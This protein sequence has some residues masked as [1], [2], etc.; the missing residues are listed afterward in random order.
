[1]E[2]VT[3]LLDIPPGN[4]NAVPV[5]Y[6]SIKFNIP[7]KS[8]LNSKMLVPPATG[9]FTNDF[10]AIAIGASLSPEATVSVIS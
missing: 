8:D 5:V 9:T 2:L 7:S 6:V 1:V 4:P 10:S 3:L